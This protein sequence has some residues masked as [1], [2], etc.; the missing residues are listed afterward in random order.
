M[1]ETL[2]Q[3]LLEEVSQ[4]FDHRDY[5][6]ATIKLKQLWKLQPENPWVQLYRGRLYEVAGNLPQAT[7]TYKNLLKAL[8]TPKVMAQARQA[9]DRVAH[10]EQEQRS[11]EIALSISSPEQQQQG[12]L[13][14]E[15]IPTHQRQA[16]SQALTQIMGIDPYSA[17]MQIP[18]RG[19]RIYRM[20]PIGEMK[21]Y[22]QQL[23]THQIPAFWLS[24]PQLQQ[25]QLFQVQTVQSD[26]SDN[27]KVELICTNPEAKTGLVSFT[28][29]EVTQVIKGRLP[30]YDRVLEFDPLRREIGQ[31]SRK[32][33]IRDYA[34]VIDL[35]LTSRNCILRFCDRTYQFD[36]G[37][38]FTPD[39]PLA[40]TITRSQ[41]N[42]ITEWIMNEQ[43]KSNIWDEFNAFC[44]AAIEFPHL[45]KLIDPGFYLPSQNKNHTHSRTNPT[46]HLYSLL[47]FCRLQFQP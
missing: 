1:S 34:L 21:L 45:L 44:E 9:L 35:H 40:Q 41:W 18:N 43:K 19:W 4:A 32:E 16:A 14:L 27:P 46:F 12:L 6:S 10:L 31:R 42:G 25:P 22:G 47:A 33:E 39:I 20:G 3:R 30:L 37:I 28:W 29:N 2:I 8:S 7:E 24:L 15:A 11:R 23:Q 5:R 17:R 13:V 36:Q 38:D 26:G